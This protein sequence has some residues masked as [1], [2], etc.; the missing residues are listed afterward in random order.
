MRV[1]SEVPLT[2]CHEPECAILEKQQ[3][4]DDVAVDTLSGVPWD[5]KGHRL[6]Q[7]DCWVRKGDVGVRV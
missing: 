7:G 3:G 2:A 4:R 1:W 6:T 5:V